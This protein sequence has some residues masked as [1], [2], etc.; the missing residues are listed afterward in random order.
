MVS[1][2]GHIG[3][4]P[5]KG[6]PG[7]EAKIEAWFVGCI[8]WVC[9]CGN[10]IGFAESIPIGIFGYVIGQRDRKIAFHRG[11]EFVLGL[12]SDGISRGVGFVIE[13]S[14]G[15][16]GA[17]GIEREEG[18]VSVPHSIGQGKNKAVVSIPVDAPEISYVGK[19]G[20]VFGKRY[21]S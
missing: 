21:R 2:A 13:D 10:F 20:K 6:I 1:I 3:G 12:H 16:E 4:I 17:V 8:I 7:D 11:V 15:L 9:T 14:G 5:I 19:G 18:I